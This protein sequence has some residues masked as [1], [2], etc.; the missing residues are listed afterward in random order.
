MT[1]GKLFNRILFAVAVL[2]LF[3]A[4]L[5]FLLPKIV[6][7][8][9][10]EI[11]FYVYNDYFDNGETLKNVIAEYQEENPLVKINYEVKKQNEF[12]QFVQEQKDQIDNDNEKNIPCVIL[13]DKLYSSAVPIEY[14]IYEEK[15]FLHYINP[16]FYNITLLKNADYNRPPKTREELLSYSQNIS[17]QP[18]APRAIALNGDVWSS[19][20]PFLF[21][22]MPN[23]ESPEKIEL[24]V[25]L[26]RRAAQD[27]FR[28]YK[29]IAKFELLFGSMF[30]ANDNEIIRAFADNNLAFAVLPSPA[31]NQI[32]ALNPNLEYSI[33]TIPPPA[34]ITGKPIFT[35]SE[36]VFAVKSD[37]ENTD[38]AKE[39]LNYLAAKRYELQ[40]AFSA[41]PL[42]ENGTW[43]SWDADGGGADGQPLIG[44]QSANAKSEALN[45]RLRELYHGGFVIPHSVLGIYPEK[46]LEAMR[47]EML[48]YISENATEQQ[49]ASAI[50]KRLGTV[51]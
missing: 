13:F 28:F 49:T 27:V 15:Y 39:F 4:L 6:E 21:A 50:Q 48:R 51:E 41:L 17:G 43:Q 40:S 1:G 11:D 3:I 34:S 12:I 5:S 25:F 9:I 36:Y 29:N 33:T 20:F 44:E 8:V 38:G 26:S 23:I 45:R 42:D 7:P 16:L 2:A 22:S 32:N 37:G 14:T 31:I 46:A 35:L 18:E 10:T 24:S 30:D 19:V 47:D